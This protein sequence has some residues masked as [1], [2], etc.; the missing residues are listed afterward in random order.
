MRSGV[1]RLTRHPNYFGEATL[2]WG[3]FL[4]AAS[5]PNGLFALISPVVIDWLLLC[6]SGIPMLE[7]KY[8]NRPEYQDY[9]RATS[10]FF[11]WFPKGV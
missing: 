6:V 8:V 3:C 4:I 9:K 5:V 10:A 11:P 2:W 7:K 1:W